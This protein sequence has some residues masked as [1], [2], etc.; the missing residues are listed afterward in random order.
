MINP[1]H[2]AVTF[3]PAQA[4]YLPSPAQVFISHSSADAILVDW[5][6]TQVQAVGCRPYL[7]ERDIQPGRAL[8]EKVREEIAASAALLVVLTDSAHSS[9][10]VQQE[11]G[12][13]VQSGLQVIPLVEHGMARAQLAM[14]DGIE[15]IRFDR[16]DLADVSANLTA[17]L[18]EIV[19]PRRQQMRARFISSRPAFSAQLEAELSLTAGQLLLGVFVVL[20]VVGC[21]YLTTHPPAAAP[22]AGVEPSR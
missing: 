22:E 20:L 6:A 17:A 19:E 3:Q 18:L 16:L 5:I 7:A 2:R 13:A 15:H 12:A 8:A 14:L 10:Y 4:T 21:V 11:I 9:S 1:N